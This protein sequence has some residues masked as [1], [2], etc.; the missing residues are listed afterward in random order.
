V[1]LADSD[2]HCPDELGEIVGGADQ[3]PALTNHL[4]AAEKKLTEASRRLDLS[5][6]DFDHLLA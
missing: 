4:D 2:R 1:P 3:R 6:D 5:E